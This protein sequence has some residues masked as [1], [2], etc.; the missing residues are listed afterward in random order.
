M[1]S[2]YYLVLFGRNNILGEKDKQLL[3]GMILNE[4]LLAMGKLIDGEIVTFD[5]NPPSKE[6]Q[7]K[8]IQ[9]II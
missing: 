1:T 4:S 9:L 3:V 7:R 8:E 6:K 2:G 5:F